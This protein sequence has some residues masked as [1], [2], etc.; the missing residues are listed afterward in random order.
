MP[1]SKYGQWSPERKARH[2]ARVRRWQKENPERA[3]AIQKNSRRK[4][5]YGL[6]P[7]DFAAMLKR[8]RGRCRICRKKL[9][10]R[11]VI[12]HSHETKKVRGLLCSP[13]NV[14]LGHIERPAW[15][16]AATAYLKEAA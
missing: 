2:N 13:C 6:T 12:D 5:Q 8:Q 14:S 16:A 9:A 10:G 15:F 1:P 7:E 3:A 11:P 4:S